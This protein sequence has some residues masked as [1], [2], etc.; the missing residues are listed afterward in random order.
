MAKRELN[1]DDLDDGTPAGTEADDGQG[2]GESRAGE[3][4]DLTEHISN[5]YDSMSDDGNGTLPDKPKEKPE[6]GPEGEGKGESDPAATA[7]GETDTAGQP[8]EGE[9]AGEQQQ[10][11]EAGTGQEG[12]Q[13]QDTEL[14]LTPEER[15]QLGERATQRFE[16]LVDRVKTTAEEKE[17]LQSERD[18]YQQRFESVAQP[19]RETGAS[20]EQLSEILDMTGE[21]VSGDVNRGQQAVQRAYS[22]IKEYAKHYGVKLPETSIVDDHPD[23][24]QQV[25]SGQ[26]TQEIAEQHASMRN[27]QRAQQTA[28]A[29]RQA[30]TQQMQ[31]VQAEANQAAQNLTQLQTQWQQNDPDFQSKAP[32]LHEYAQQ[33]ANEVMDGQRNPGEVVSLMQ[34]RYN[35][36]S[37]AMKTAADST[38]AANKE[39][40]PIRPGA[41]RGGKSQQAP[42]SI[43]EAVN[44]A[45]DEM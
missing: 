36:I 22:M 34:D 24:Q 39:P 13:E 2:G 28:S 12:E 18:D 4:F 32:M 7:E 37:K 21:L 44:I 10:A 19:L 9:S 45:Y 11:G 31:Q 16:K 35:T 14:E 41:R 40:N 27:M 5:T 15:E 25:E 1:H 43:E 8:G 42:K 3:Q 20:P 33:L 17:A 38:R 30:T 26:I 23:L 6:T 29:N